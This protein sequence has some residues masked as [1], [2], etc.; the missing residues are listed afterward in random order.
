MSSLYNQPV[1]EDIVSAFKTTQSQSW[2]KFNDKLGGIPIKYCKKKD[3]F[4]SENP[5]ELSDEDIPVFGLVPRLEQLMLVSCN[6]CSMIVKRDCIH[7]HYNRRHNNPENDNFSLERF[8]L[9][10]VKTNKHKKQKINVR[11]LPEKKMTDGSRNIDPVI[12]HIK[13]EFD[14][15]EF[16][17]LSDIN[18]VV[19]KQENEIQYVN[20]S[21]V[22][23]TLKSCNPSTSCGVFD[24]T[25]KPCDQNLVHYTVDDVTTEPNEDFNKLLSVLPHEKEKLLNNKCSK[26]MNNENNIDYITNS[27]ELLTKSLNSNKKIKPK[28]TIDFSLIMSDDDYIED[29]SDKEHDRNNVNSKNNY[30]LQNDIGQ[31]KFSTDKYSNNTSYANCDD[32]I[33]NYYHSSTES[34]NIKKEFLPINKYSNFVSDEEEIEDIS[35][36]VFD[37]S[38][39]NLLNNEKKCSS[40]T[41]YLEF[42]KNKYSSDVSSND[43]PSVLPFSV[44]KKTELAR[45][46]KYTVDINNESSNNGAKEKTQLA[47]N[48][49][50]MVKESLDDGIKETNQTQNNQY[51]DMNIGNLGNAD[52]V[53]DRSPTALLNIAEESKSS[54]T[55]Y[56]SDAIDDDSCYDG[57]YKGYC[58]LYKGYRENLALLGIMSDEEE[59]NDDNS[60]DEIELNEK[61]NNEETSDEDASNEEYF[62]EEV[63]DEEKNVEEAYFNNDEIYNFHGFNDLHPEEKNFNFEFKSD[64][65]VNDLNEDENGCE[66]NYVTNEN[67]KN[68]PTAFLDN[69]KELKPFLISDCISD[70]IDDE[71]CYDNFYKGYYQLIKEYHKKLALLGIMSE[72]E[73]SDEEENDVKYFDE[74][75]LDA[76]NIKEVNDMEL[77]EE[78]YFNEVESDG[79]E[80][81]KE[82]SDEEESN[83]DDYGNESSDE[84]NDEEY[85]NE[86][87][88]NDEVELDDEESVD[89]ENH[90]I[91]NFKDNYNSFPSK[92]KNNEENTKYKLN[93]EYP[94]VIN[95]DYS[96]DS[97]TS[98]NQSQTALLDK[99]DKLKSILDIDYSDF[100]I[101]NDGIVNNF[102]NGCYQLSSES[103]LL[104]N[105]EPSLRKSKTN[106]SI[107]NCIQSSSVESLNTKIKIK[108]GTKDG[109]LDFTNDVDFNDTITNNDLSSQDTKKETKYTQTDVFLNHTN[110]KQFIDHITMVDESMIEAL[111]A[112]DEE[113]KCTQTD[114][115]IECIDCYKT[116]EDLIDSYIPVSSNVEILEDFINCYTPNHSNVHVAEYSGNNLA[117]NIS[118]AKIINNTLNPNSVEDSELLNSDQC[119]SNKSHDLSSSIIEN[120]KQNCGSVSYTDKLKQ[121]YILYHNAINR[122]IYLDKNY[123]ICTDRLKTISDQIVYSKNCKI[124]PHANRHF[125]AKVKKNLKRRLGGQVADKENY[126]QWI[127]GSFKKLK[128]VEFVVRKTICSEESCNNDNVDE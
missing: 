67:S 42:M 21:D 60:F 94:N 18:Q 125:E 124:I 121:E 5:I 103:E 43:N 27:T 92:M 70:E 58:L 95:N 46:N 76:E 113:T 1:V 53:Y 112:I 86:L 25:L 72:E 52:I 41:E 104:N 3:I 96:D 114:L 2:S 12:Q 118:K 101:D 16:E 20:E 98:Y 48:N 14:E 19:V 87:E 54:I 91:E 82:G 77:N 23:L 11:K 81:A 40:N 117:S 79:E 9:P 57:S 74:I 128:R 4:K 97:L 116:A 111:S 84:K 17:R 33:S 39:T 107:I 31:S 55:D 105:K 62:D 36:M 127:T 22:N 10:T 65:E 28:L 8:I 30:R 50:Y 106:N 71:N 6:K 90:T 110:H 78:E 59:E 37:Q 80:N 35:E 85:V 13:T 75:V 34:P 15:L 100:T 115:S 51:I 122:L 93:H 26:I 24:W 56:L 69:K 32:T 123:P 45:H 7:Y 38:P 89:K 73:E 49:K 102:K 63:S 108:P 83:E 99:K 126:N 119:S 109:S 88:I 47:R 66:E 29:E 61:E 120:D 68:S 64:D 44:N